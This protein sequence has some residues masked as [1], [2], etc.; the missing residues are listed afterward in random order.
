M[1]WAGWVICSPH[2][3][4]SLQLLPQIRYLRVKVATSKRHGSP[5][6][7]AS[8]LQTPPHNMILSLPRAHVLFD[9]LQLIKGQ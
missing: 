4:L 5:Q 7:T 9:Q 6:E 1:L 2:L 3:H 8:N